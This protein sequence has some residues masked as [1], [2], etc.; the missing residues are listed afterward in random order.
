MNLRFFQVGMIVFGCAGCHREPGPPAHSQAV[1]P[2]LATP[3]PQAAAPASPPAP[4][5]EDISG[6]VVETMNAA[7]YTYARLDRGGTELWIAGPQAQLAIGTKLGRMDGMVMTNF[8]SEALARTFE[9]IYFVNAYAGAGGAA[10]GGAAAG[11][12]AADPHAGAAAS[13]AAVKMDKVA[14]VRGGKTI[15]EIISGKAVLA[16]KPVV[17]RG[18]V[19]KF[20][21]GILD[22][23]WIH[24]RDGSAADGG[25]DLLVTTSAQAK[26]GDVIVA[27]GTVAVD[28]DFGAGYSYAIIVENATLAAQ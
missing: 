25:D 11:G 1:S 17:V 14:P 5:G 15:A 6:Q 12:A 3:S 10:V 26:L 20:N 8:R 24:L 16:G 28:K 19:V 23:N 22:R 18:K 27:R 9:R 21:S 7:G 4:A 13:A 2:P